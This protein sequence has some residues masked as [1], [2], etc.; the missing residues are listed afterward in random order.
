M[1]LPKP[2]RGLLASMRVRKKLIVLHT[3]FSAILAVILLVTI[4]PT[5]IDLL[6]RAEASQSRIVLDAI[7]S[8]IG[9][10]DPSDLRAAAERLAPNTTLLIGTADEV[11]LDTMS[12]S[13]ALATP[14]RAVIATSQRVGTCAILFAP[15]NGQS[16][17]YVLATPV[18]GGSEAITR[19]YLLLVVALLS[20]YALVAVAL[21]ALVLPQ[22]VY[23][24]IRKLLAADQAVQE[25]RPADEI[26]PNDAI[27]ADE[28][29]EIM[30]SRN[31]VIQSLRAKE[32]ALAD[33]L[34]ELE[35]VANDLTR[36]NHLLETARRN[37]ADA[38]RLASLG[39]MSAGIAH[40]LNTP[41][42]VLKGMV[43]QVNAAPRAGIEPAQSALMVRVVAR[44]ERLGE[45]LLDF[46]RVRPPRIAPAAIREVVDEAITLV[47][48][49]REARDVEFH[50]TVPAEFLVPC[51]GDRLVQVFVN[52]LRNAVDASRAKK[53]STSANFNLLTGASSLRTVVIE[54]DCAM[55]D[56]TQW[57]QIRVM[58]NGPGIDPSILPHVFEPFSTTRLDARGTG[59]GLAVSDGI[60]REHGGLI[61]A[62]NRLDTSG[63]IFEIVLPIREEIL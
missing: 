53:Y 25:G 15:Q 19:L 21:E 56:A 8:G 7:S 32:R 62:R 60:A 11:G 33:A 41:L 63:A 18:E 2:R 48:L 13:M 27:P 38:D 42:A 51:D 31:E 6:A 34:G 29:G 28:L 52:L 1:L 23:R 46:A 36:K 43:E 4:R 61:L 14:G 54:A 44:L 20:V 12:S 24:P 40:E 3:L 37:L 10:G 22:S 5:M 17:Y 47:R 45:S 9:R 58:D 39:M 59:L 57:A 55:R 49:D 35:R 30:R 50:N 26:I 16:V